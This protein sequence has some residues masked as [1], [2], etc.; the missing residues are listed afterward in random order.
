[1]IYMI[2]KLLSI[3]EYM[4]AQCSLLIIR[5]CGS[6]WQLQF[7]DQLM[8]GQPVV[9]LS[10]PLLREQASWQPEVVATRLPQG[11]VLHEL[12]YAPEL[13]PYL[14]K[15]D[16]HVLAIVSQDYYVKEQLETSFG[17][18]S[19]K[20]QVI[21]TACSSAE[22]SI[23]TLPLVLS[24]RQPF[25]PT[26]MQEEATDVIAAIVQGAAFGDSADFYSR[27]IKE[28]IQRNVMDL[29]T[30]S[31]DVKLYRFMCAVAAGVGSLVNYASLG[32]AAGI[33][34]PTAKQW[35][36]FLQGAGIVYLL[37]PIEH[38]GLNRVAKAPKA[39]FTDTGLAA[40]LLRIGSKEELSLSP[41]FGGLLENYVVCK[42]RNRYLSN[43]IEPRLSFFRDS[44]AKEIS[45]LL[46]ADG[47]L[48][49][50]D[51]SKESVSANKLLK[52]YSILQPIEDAADAILGKGALL[53]LGNRPKQWS[54]DLEFINI[55]N[56]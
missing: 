16:D 20:K 29:T 53:T 22:V 34:T 25:L 49:P 40:Y 52:K 18:F 1:M 41:F 2:N 7:L 51:I 55:G 15:A 30:I 5:H 26:G 4:H 8:Q 39:Y 48:Y 37:Q 14:L 19:M 44:N 43:G 12:Q 50:M 56:V 24:D 23:L 3:I 17:D 45:L 21:G 33:S 11:A 28:F 6:P 31:S 10:D 38:T 47:V 27:Y 9:D 46:E 54:D 42:I 36:L 32:K 13:V 35:L